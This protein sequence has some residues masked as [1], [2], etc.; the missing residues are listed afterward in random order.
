MATVGHPFVDPREVV[1]AAYR[2]IGSDFDKH[3]SAPW[4]FV[5]EWL[6]D[7]PVRLAEHPALLVAGCGHGRH[8][9]CVTVGGEGT[10]GTPRRP[11]PCHIVRVGAREHR[12]PTPGP[13]HS[14]GLNQTEGPNRVAV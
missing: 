6:M 13:D 11:A 4:T 7:N 5:V 9:R 2:Q 8:L 12:T 14:D 1:D 10:Q 3:R